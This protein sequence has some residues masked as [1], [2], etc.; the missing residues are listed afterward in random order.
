MLTEKKC[1]CFLGHISICC[2]VGSCV[3]AQEICSAWCPWAAGDSLLLRGPLWAAGSCCSVP[4]APPALT[5]VP[6]GL[7]HVFSL[8]SPSFLSHS[9]F[10]F[11]N[12][13]LPE[14]Q[15]PSFM[16]QLKV[17]HDC[18]EKLVM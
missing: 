1:M 5:A 10:P 17:K 11:L 2:T 16:A 6:A 12:H 9:A 14:T 15:P 8:F 7:L 18:V 4:G 13:A 3:A